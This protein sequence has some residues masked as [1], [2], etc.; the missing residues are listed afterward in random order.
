MR[1]DEQKEEKTRLL[2]MLITAPINYST[3]YET[4]FQIAAIFHWTIYI[5][6]VK[7]MEMELYCCC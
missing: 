4:M 5:D 3:D 2:I 7:A 6:E 1:K